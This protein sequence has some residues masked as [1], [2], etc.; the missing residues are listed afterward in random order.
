MRRRFASAGF[1]A[2]A[3]NLVLTTGVAAAGETYESFQIQPTPALPPASPRAAV[4][5]SYMMIDDYTIQTPSAGMID[6]LLR[7]TYAPTAHS[8]IFADTL[9]A[10]PE[11]QIL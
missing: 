11:F 10:A 1:L 9:K 2:L 8:L 6:A 7:Q 5:L 4:K 3:A